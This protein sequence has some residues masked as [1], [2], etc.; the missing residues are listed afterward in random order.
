[1]YIINKVFMYSIHKDN[2]TILV[3][4]II[5]CF[6]SPHTIKNVLMQWIWH[7]HREWKSI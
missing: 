3:Y 4:L 6:H 1:M 2:F 7:D 5:Q